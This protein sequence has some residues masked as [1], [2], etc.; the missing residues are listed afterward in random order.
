MLVAL[1]V[2]EYL[3]LLSFAS[4]N[5]F[6]TLMPGLDQQEPPIPC[7]VVFPVSYPGQAIISV[8]P[9]L[10]TCLHPATRCLLQPLGVSSPHPA[11]YLCI[12]L[13]TRHDPPSTAQSLASLKVSP[14]ISHFF[15]HPSS[16][17]SALLSN[18]TAFVF[19]PLSYHL[20]HHCPRRRVPS[21]TQQCHIS[22]TQSVSAR[23]YC[24]PSHGQ[25]SDPRQIPG[26]P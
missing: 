8:T 17:C 5:A 22:G 24:W 3:H 7:Q 25:T 12:S 9:V 26:L 15:F 4:T 19:S 13:P 14:S 20:Q 23:C 11:G 6:Y 21:N 10:H 1:S 18:S 16:P 2:L